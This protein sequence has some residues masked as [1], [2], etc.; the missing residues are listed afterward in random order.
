MKQR[1]LFLEENKNNY[2]NL[3]YDIAQLLNSNNNSYSHDII[4]KLKELSKNDAKYKAKLASNDKGVLYF[5]IGTG[6]EEINSAVTKMLG[7]EFNE[8]TKNQKEIRNKILKPDGT[9]YPENL[10][11]LEKAMITGESQPDVEVM[12]PSKNGE[13]KW[14]SASSDPVYD[15]N[16]VLIGA[17]LFL[18]DITTRKNKELELIKENK[19]LLFS[20]RAFVQAEKLANSGNWL[21]DLKSKSFSISEG[22]FRLLEI[23]KEGFDGDF[24][25][26]VRS[27]MHPEDRKLL[28]GRL[29]LATSGNPLPSTEYRN[30]F[31]DGRIKIFKAEASQLILDK[32]GKP[33]LILGILVDITDERHK[34][35]EKLEEQS[36]QHEKRIETLRILA[37]EINHDFNNLLAVIYG[38]IDLAFD[39]HKESTYLN[40]AINSLERARDLSDQILS[41]TK[42][43]VVNREIIDIGKLL[44]KKASF[45]NLNPLISIEYEISNDLLSFYGNRTQI[46]YVFENIIRNAIQSI[47]KS[48]T[49]KIQA[50]NFTVDFSNEDH[51]YDY[52]KITIQDSGSGMT[53]ETLDHV[54]EP[55]F[56]TKVNG[57]GLGLATSYS[58]VLNHSGKIKVESEL[59]IGSTFYIYLPLSKISIERP[60]E[61]YESKNYIG[62][63]DFIVLEDNK[64]LQPILKIYLESFGFTTYIKSTGDE[65]LSLLKSDMI[66]NL[67]IKGMLISLYTSSNLGGK[68]IIKEI[69]RDYPNIP[70][71][72]SSS[73]T[74]Y[75]V[76][77]FPREYSFTA[78]IKKPFIKTELRSLLNKHIGPS[79]KNKS[80]L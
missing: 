62:D 57:K 7:Y 34:E 17:L 54:F 10:L 12:I 55:F 78:S 27:R 46:G 63:G 21:Y 19:K 42:I 25:K 15:N 73:F 56:T 74:D 60:E 47:Q 79:L 40:S 66:S 2:E 33:D 26:I 4:S 20:E 23:D 13:L 51:I 37:S 71:F 52:I 16:A 43:G 75:P 64:D 48:G 14:F 58:I 8:I 24:V 36:L 29:K 28:E 11:P 39:E 61:E 1:V 67:D 76:I 65:I 35:Q 5:N 32:D 44:F 72:V 49:I 69:R 31:P 77:N 45:L 9:H 70:V 3:I 68:E 41:F 59:L 38:Y 18:E 50:E 53:K 30:V 22:M 6:F 80:I